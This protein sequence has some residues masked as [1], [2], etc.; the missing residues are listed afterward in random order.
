MALLTWVKAMPYAITIS[1]HAIP[2]ENSTTGTS[3]LHLCSFQGGQV[4]RL[5]VDTRR[6]VCQILFSFP[7]AVRTGADWNSTKFL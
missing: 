1:P 6:V 4:E 3:I 2:R 7:F 5:E